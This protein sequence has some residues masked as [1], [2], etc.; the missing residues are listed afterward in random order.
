MYKLLFIF[1]PIFSFAQSNG[2]MLGNSITAG[3]DSYNSIGYYLLDECNIREG[4]SCNVLAVGGNSITQQRDRWMLDDNRLN[5][6]WITIDLGICDII[7]GH[8]IEQILEDYRQL[9][10]T[11]NLTKKPSAKII[12][13]TI[14]PIKKYLDIH[15]VNQPV[16]YERWQLLNSAI[17]GYG[18][19][20][21]E[22]VNYRCS[23]NTDMLNNNGYLL[24]KYDVGDGVHQTNACRVLI[25][26]NYKSVLNRLG[27]LNCKI[28]KNTIS[29]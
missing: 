16:Y 15:F 2:V 17:M 18:T 19:E 28:Y 1:L 29:K 10:T 25:A 8:T 11:I 21:I 4:N 3:W 12:I 24:P 26:K 7:Y 13:F 14:T 27:F 9:I 20:R 6:D 23:L 5:Y 22:G